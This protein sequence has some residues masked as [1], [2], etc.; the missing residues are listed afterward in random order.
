MKYLNFK[1]T[2]VEDQEVEDIQYIKEV[3]EREVIGVVRP[4][5]RRSETHRR[6][7]TWHLGVEELTIVDI[8]NSLQGW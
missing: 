8:S 5:S 6:R 1:K 2:Q 3:E 4:R 7:K